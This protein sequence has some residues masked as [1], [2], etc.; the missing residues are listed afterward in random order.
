MKIFPSNMKVNKDNLKKTKLRKLAVIKLNYKKYQKQ[1]IR[2]K[3][4]NSGL[5]FRVQK[6]RKTSR[7]DK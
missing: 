4:T 7:M 6:E 5:E 1:L 3:T 2:L